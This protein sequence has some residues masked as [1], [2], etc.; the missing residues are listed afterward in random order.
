MPALKTGPTTVSSAAPSLAG[1]TSMSW[2][3]CRTAW[4]TTTAFG[5]SSLGSPV[6]LLE[7]TGRNGNG[8]ESVDPCR[9]PQL[10]DQGLGHLG[11]RR[12]PAEVTRAG[13][14]LGQ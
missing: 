1:S 10:R 9:S 4:S 13:L 12:G 7:V 2:A 3:P 14:R 5:T 6:P 8:T 11:R